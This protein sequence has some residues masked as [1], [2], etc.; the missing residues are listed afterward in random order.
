LR[1]G[2]RYAVVRVLATTPARLDDSTH[3]AIK[4]ILFEEWLEDRRRVARIE[5]YWGNADRTSPKA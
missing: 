2:D 1:S 3:S 4:K 5:W